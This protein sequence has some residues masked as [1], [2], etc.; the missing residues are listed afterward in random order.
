MKIAIMF[1]S[2]KTLWIVRS[3]FIVITITVF[4]LS[5]YYYDPRFYPFS[6]LDQKYGQAL[7]Y[8]GTLLGITIFAWIFPVPGSI[9]ATTYGIISLVVGSS[10]TRSPS[11]PSAIYYL[12][13]GL[14]LVAAIMYFVI[15]LKQESTRVKYPPNK[16]ILSAVRIITIIA[17]VVFIF[18]YTVVYLD[19]W[20]FAAIPALLTLGIAW[21]WPAAGGTLM[22]LVGIPAF[23]N[24]YDSN[25]DFQM[26]LPAYILCLIFIVSGLMHI[27]ASF[28]WKRGKIKRDV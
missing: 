24:L 12:I 18:I 23:Y 20:V 2:K 21:L 26:K 7:L 10:G 8:G 25:Y 16:K 15:G 5:I 4:V 27:A 1:K 28:W 13:Y 6:H 11:I 14:F 3:C 19:W 22:L 9:I 17:L